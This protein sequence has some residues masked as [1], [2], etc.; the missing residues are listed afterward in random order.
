MTTKEAAQKILEGSLVVFPTETVYGLGALAENDLA[1]ESIFRVKGRPAHNPLI[2]HISE[3]HQLDELVKEIS[4]QARK[5]M[6]QF[7]PGPLTICF[8]KS[9]AV[10]SLVS[11]GLDTVCVR[12][13]DHPIARELLSFV[14]KAVA[15]PSANLSGKPST[16]N[17]EDA[18][19]QLEAKGVSILD[20]GHTPLGIESTVV[21]CSGTTVKILRPGIIGKE[22]IEMVLG[23]D[24][25]DESS[26][27]RTSS[28]GQLLEH[29]APHGNLQVI[30]GPKELR[31][32]WIQEHI[33][34]PE[35][36]VIGT[37][38]ESLDIPFKEIFTL[39]TDETD[40][41]QYA[42]KLYEF[43]NWCDRKQAEKILLE[44]PS[45]NNPLL[46]SLINRL[47]KASK[48]QVVRL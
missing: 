12:R 10:S 48:G 32:Q 20:G 17:Y 21:D 25:I 6:E 11:G 23:Q 15:A 13:P 42:S 46:V 36:W 16:T 35:E 27:E 40:L 14:G 43:L 29:Y 44:L 19:L 34:H 45:S 2:L 26:P 37:F 4:P 38:A 9:E 33:S 1:V 30:F 24:V 3:N 5:L 7:W 28:P 18:V 39:S 31:S 41:S 47:E 8:L 22:Q